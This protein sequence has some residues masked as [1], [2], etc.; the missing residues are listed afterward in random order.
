MSPSELRKR[1]K[2][3]ADINEAWMVIPKTLEI[4]RKPRSRYQRFIG[5]FWKNRYRVSNLYWWQSKKWASSEMMLFP[6][7]IKHDDIPLKGYPRKHIL[8]GGWTIPKEDLAVLYEGPLLAQ[9]GNEILVK[10]QSKL[11]SMVSLISLL[12]PISWIVG[13]A[14]LCLRYRTEL[15]ELLNAVKNYI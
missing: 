8:Q 1:E 10:H 13:F 15:L 5:L 4:A 12:K 3:I 14:L 7:A 9:S 6:D 11:Q 2:A